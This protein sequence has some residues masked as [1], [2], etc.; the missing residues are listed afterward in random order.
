MA[1]VGSTRRQ[2]KGSQVDTTEERGR[3]DADHAVTNHDVAHEA[4]LEGAVSDIGD[5][6]GNGHAA[7][8]GLIH[9]G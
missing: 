8:A 3:S 9:K 1:D 6:V 2:R 4:G 7:Y 5:A